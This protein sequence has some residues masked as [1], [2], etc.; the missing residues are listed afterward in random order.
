MLTEP[1]NSVDKGITVR[2]HS[3]DGVTVLRVEQQP[4][5]MSTQAEIY[6]T[7]YHIYTC[8]FSLTTD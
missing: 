5:E 4:A 6:F 1:D 7:L 8:K 3:L 2:G